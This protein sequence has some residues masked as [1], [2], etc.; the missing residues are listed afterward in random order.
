MDAVRAV[1]ESGWITTGDVSSG[2]ER[3][4][5]AYLG[6]DHVVACSSNT[7]AEE[8][9]LA[10]LDLPTGSRVGIP[11]WTFASTGIA[12]HRVGLLPVLLDVDEDDLNLSALSLE[13]ALNAEPGLDAVVGVHYGGRA[14]SPEIRRL[15]SR[16]SIP[17]IEDAAHALGTSDDRGL[18]RGSGETLA[19]CFSFYATKNLS[20]A[21][22]G[23]IATS[24][25]GLAEFARTFRLHG[26]SADAIDRYRRPGAHAYDILQ[27]GLKAN[28]PDILAALGRSQLARF[29]K[30]QA[31][32]RSIMTDYRQRL[33]GSETSLRFVPGD[34]DPRSADHLAVIDAGCRDRRDAIIAALSAAK[35]GSSVHFRPLHTFSWFAANVPIG[36]SGVEICDRM[37]GRIMS[38][39]LHVNLSN[40]DVARICDVVLTAVADFEQHG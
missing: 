2:F 31:R 27:P 21:E 20:T 40:D 7:M 6:A 8:I 9:C 38:L 37:D 14:M 35:V 13:A 17:F 10:Y 23:A 32:R 4:L 18:I 30:M 29:E 26:M 28:F 24:D 22:G 11:S 36:P 16:H 3:D 19:A 1:L 12:A 15:C 39:P 5:E 25:A 34:L 33:G